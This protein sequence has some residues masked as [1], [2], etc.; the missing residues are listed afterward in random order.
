MAYYL[1]QSYNQPSRPQGGFFSGIAHFLTGA[2]QRIAPATAALP[3]TAGA[4]GRFVQTV[5]QHPVV[6]AAG[7]AATTV[8]V[9]TALART[10][11]TGAAATAGAPPAMHVHGHLHVGGRAKRAPGAPRARKRMNVC[12]PHALRRAIRRAHGFERFARKVISFPFHSRKAGRGV[13]KRK[14]RAK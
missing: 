11:H 9:G 5:A 1:N 8:A 3:G 10:G 12:N 7:A 6:S 14:R 4:V 2:V 13:F